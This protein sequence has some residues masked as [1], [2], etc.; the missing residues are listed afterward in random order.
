MCFKY[1]LYLILLLLQLGCYHTSA[2]AASSGYFCHPDFYQ[3]VSQKGLTILPHFK[4]IQQSTDYTCGPVVIQMVTQYFQGQP[5]H[6]EMT[7][8]ALVHCKPSKGTSIKNLRGYFRKLDWQVDSS[9]DSR[10]PEKPEEFTSFVLQ[11]LRS[12]TPIMVENVDWGG[13]WR[14][15]IGYDTMLTPEITDDVI[16][17]ADPYDLGDQL[18]DGYVIE[19]AQKFFYMWFSPL[20]YA[21]GARYRHWVT[22]RPLSSLT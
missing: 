13:H 8:M 3:A 15:I 17:L 19:N 12:N 14:I 2:A 16:I 9:E 20:T 4:T 11:R 22:A 18:R 1:L 5:L 7:T 10:G 21:P 6:D